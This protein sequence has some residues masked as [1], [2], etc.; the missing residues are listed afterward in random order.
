MFLSNTS[1]RNDSKYPCKNTLVLLTI[2]IFFLLHHDNLSVLPRP[3]TPYC[4]VSNLFSADIKVLY[5]YKV[6]SVNLT[7]CT[8]IV[9]LRS[10]S[11]TGCGGA[12]LHPIVKSAS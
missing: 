1:I 12:E 5:K 11:L 2:S 8:V 10:K 7:V 6:T 3:D 4:L 9:L